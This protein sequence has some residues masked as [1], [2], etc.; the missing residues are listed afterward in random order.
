MA[1]DLLGHSSQILSL[2]RQEHK[3]C[4]L[5]DAGFVK[6]IPVSNSFRREMPAV[7]PPERGEGVWGRQKQNFR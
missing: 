3:T 5:Q 7:L 1:E 4:W 6:L 2:V